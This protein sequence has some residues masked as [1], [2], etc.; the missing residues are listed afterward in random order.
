MDSMEGYGF[1]GQSLRFCGGGRNNETE[2][3]IEGIPNTINL[4]F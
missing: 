3:G 2:G 4:L 1:N